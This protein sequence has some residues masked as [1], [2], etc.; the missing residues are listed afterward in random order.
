MRLWKSY[1]RLYKGQYR[2]FFLSVLLSIV[3]S[4]IVVPVA[5]LVRHIFD[6][7]L[8]EKDFRQLI[9]L[10]VTISILY[11]LNGAITL[12]TRYISLKMTKSVI[13]ILRNTIINKLYLLPRQYFTEIDRM[14]L[15]A[16]IV[17][18]T[19]RLDVMS[20]GL[21]AQLFPAALISGGLFLVLLYL[22]LTLFLFVMMISPFLI[23]FGKFISK[24]LA[25][26]VNIYHRYFE[27]FSKRV[28]ILLNNIDLS[29]VSVSENR[30]K[31]EQGK[32]HEKIEKKS[33]DQAW[34]SA[35]YTIFNETTTSAF[36]LVIMILGGYRVINGLMTIGGLFAFFTTLGLLKKYMVMISG[37]IPKVIEGNESLMSVF[38]FLNEK[39]ELPYSGKTNF[40]FRGEITFE[41][42]SFSYDRR[43]LF[44]NISFFIN[45]GEVVYLTG[46]N[47]SG[48]STIVNLI[49]GFYRP[50][51]GIIKADGRK[52]DEIDI[53]DIR[54]R[55]GV[56]FQDTFIF[57]GTIRENIVYGL[58]NVSGDCLARAIRL[59]C[60][61][62]F[63][64]KLPEG[65]DTYIENKR[66]KLSGGEIQKIAIARSLL[67]NNRLIILDEPS[68][69][70]DKNSLTEIIRNLR[71][72]MADSTILIIS[73]KDEL[74]S[75]TEKTIRISQG[76]LKKV[77]IRDE[78]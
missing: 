5:L 23:V 3:Q 67:G 13:K 10:C 47:G 77:N 16:K 76:K 64:E 26:R 72:E 14:K 75:I 73:H 18:D 11:I 60:S 22:D 54:R 19:F 17:Q 15:H 69:H 71:T 68:T 25:S 24:I 78:T 63:I 56:V 2:K 8:P 40:E 20:N 48:K 49:L 66:E 42:V 45:P 52:Y 37:V 39:M 53:R 34:F 57:P 1:I 70:L 58:D 35:F 46:P 27:T 59:S 30:E 55:T 9:I 50:V 41:S 65:L 29:R 51:S 62:E 4:L 38:G 31:K 6:K 33:F 7:A 32:L 43:R 36:G 44:K 74:A 21:V 61:G 28:M 12:W